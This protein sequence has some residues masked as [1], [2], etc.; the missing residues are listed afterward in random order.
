MPTNNAQITSHISKTVKVYSSQSE[1][2]GSLGLKHFMSKEVD[3][4]EAF[5]QFNTKS[6]LQ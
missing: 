2:V 4:L 1:R 6:H 3:D 5:P